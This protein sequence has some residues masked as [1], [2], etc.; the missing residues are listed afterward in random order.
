MAVLSTVPSLGFS[1]PPEHLSHQWMLN[2]LLWNQSCLWNNAYKCSIKQWAE[3]CIYLDN[4]YYDFCYC[5]RN[6]INCLM[7]Y[8]SKKLWFVSVRLPNL[9]LNTVFPE[10]KPSEYQH[11]THTP[12]PR[13]PPAVPATRVHATLWQLREASPWVRRRRKVR[14]LEHWR[15]SFQTGSSRWE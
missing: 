13:V 6:S 2:K 14:P 1:L 9:T 3:I 4:Y 8:T 10:R 7:I 12:S 11:D 5:F 15:L